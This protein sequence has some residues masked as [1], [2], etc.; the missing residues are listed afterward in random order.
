VQN[1]SGKINNTAAAEN[2]ERDAKSTA[3]FRWFRKTG[4]EP[5]IPA[6]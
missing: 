6:P 5:A 1:S 4:L 2:E 3:F